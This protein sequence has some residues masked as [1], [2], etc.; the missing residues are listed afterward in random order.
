M[1]LSNLGLILDCDGTL[2]DTIDAW[3]EA[4]VHVCSRVGYTLTPQQ[5]D[6]I[7]TLTLE[8][9]SVYFSDELH[10]CGTPEEALRTIDGYMT[11]FYENAALAMPG[12]VDFV[13]A[14]A[15]AGAHMTVVS[16][17]PQNYL[18]SGLAHAGFSLDAFE[19]VLSA[20][21]L[22][23]SKRERFIFDRALEIMGLDAWQAW[24]F[25][26]TVYALK[27]MG[28]MGCHTVGMYS[29]DNNATVAELR[30]AADAAFPGGFAECTPERFFELIGA[31]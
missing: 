20:S 28:D 15:H 11:A 30:Q 31:A 18:D 27:V 4:E 3:H 19:A 10:V 9:A 22:N 5:V 1:D 24:G 14:L 6:Y 2:L 13:A 25:D 17:S 16:S 12:A 23:T 26:D 29:A 7:N 21:A 8:E